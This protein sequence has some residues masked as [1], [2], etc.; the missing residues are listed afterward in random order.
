[1]QSKM[2]I[3]VGVLCAGMLAWQFWPVP[4]GTSPAADA[5]TNEVAAVVAEVRQPESSNDAAAAER[6]QAP[7]VATAPAQPPPARP[8]WTASGRIVDEETNQGIAR[9]VIR[10]AI[11][12]NAP[13]LGWDN[14]ATESRADGTFTLDFELRTPGHLELEVRH[15]DHAITH[16]P[17]QELVARV[18]AEGSVHVAVGDVLMARGGALSGRVLAADGT[19]PVPGAWIQPYRAAYGAPMQFFRVL[20]IDLPH[21]S[22][23]NSIVA[24]DSGHFVL[25]SR[26]GPGHRREW[27]VA[28]TDDGIGW[29]ELQPSR[30]AHEDAAFDIVLR[31]AATLRAHVVDVAGRPLEGAVVI[32]YP[33]CEPISSPYD[34]DRKS[35]LELPLPRFLRH[36]TNGRGVAELHPPI[37]PD[38]FQFGTKVPGGQVSVA[39]GLAGHRRWNQTIELSP[40][41]VRD[42]E[43]RLVAGTEV[44]IAGVVLTRDGAPIAAAAVTIGKAHASTD[45]SGRFRFE[46]VDVAEGA[47]Q[48]QIEA[49]GF[50]S[51]SEAVDCHSYRREHSVEFRLDPALAVRGIVVDQDGAPVAQA[52]VSAG[53]GVNTETRDD[54]RFEL[55][56]VPLAQRQLVVTG[57]RVGAPFGALVSP[58]PE[59]LPGELRIVVQRNRGGARVEIALRDRVTGTP[60]EP[61]ACWLFPAA[62]D[63]SQG[64]GRPLQVRDGLC[65]DVDT[66]AGQ[67]RVLAEMRDGRRVERTLEVPAGVPVVREQLLLDPAGSVRCTLDLSL[68]AKVPE[69]VRV[70]ILP[71]DAG[72]LRV[73]G[74]TGGPPQGDYAV[75]LSPA[76]ER[77][78]EVTGVRP[79][80][81]FALRVVDEVVGEVD[82]VVAPGGT[83]AVTMQLLPA[84]RLELS[85]GRAAL[86]D[87]VLVHWKRADATWSTPQQLMACRGKQSLGSIVVPAGAVAWR[88]GYLPEGGV[89]TAREGKITVPAGGSASVR[90]D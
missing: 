90:I 69:R 87:N 19:T 58:I 59:P 32:A 75:L 51:C 38:G 55:A 47:V 60:V 6:S 50:V 88:V 21:P 5:M 81:P 7:I 40:G 31:P 54:G 63:G 34:P 79:D 49:A 85:C 77:E 10:F 64:V 56:G 66:P 24:D 1:M 80:T 44:D 43:V 36:T 89:M 14:P 76:A 82:T 41:E 17:L 62:K 25:P 67:Y 13:P 86:F 27:L 72:R 71:F 52:F 84:G 78:I 48:V 35:P 11:G 46:S 70:E 39:V 61:A 83:A 74:R 29:R 28:F 37:G 65:H 53:P 68:L 16:V 15:R 2:V 9:A 26:L 42:L 30:R 4:E 57:N 73:V 12:S 33:A 45:A 23:P 20:G 18:R 22:P 3:G 8:A